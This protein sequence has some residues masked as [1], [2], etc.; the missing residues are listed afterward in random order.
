MRHAVRDCGGVVIIAI[1][2][3]EADA[4]TV[5]RLLN[6][7][8]VRLLRDSERDDRDRREARRIRLS[9]LAALRRESAQALRDVPPDYSVPLLPVVKRRKVGGQ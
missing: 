2:L 4:R 8:D 6:I 7:I 1:A 3:S 9:L 5:A